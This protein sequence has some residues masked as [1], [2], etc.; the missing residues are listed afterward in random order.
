MLET[1]ARHERGA[2]ADG[3]LAA[4]KSAADCEGA[5]AGVVIAEDAA[6]LARRPTA[7]LFGFQVVER[8]E[9]R[10]SRQAPPHRPA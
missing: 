10:D 4:A 9:C 6:E 1:L 8:T 5:A 3:R 7:A 2:L